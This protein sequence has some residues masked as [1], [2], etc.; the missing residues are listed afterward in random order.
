MADVTLS[1]SLN[2][3]IYAEEV[4][5]SAT[6]AGSDAGRLD[7]R[8]GDPYLTGLLKTEPNTIFR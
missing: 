4:T 7:Q 8:G 2:P 3:S 6:V 5:F 1:L